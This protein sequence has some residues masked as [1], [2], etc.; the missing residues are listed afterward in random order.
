MQPSVER[1]LRT[2][3]EEIADRDL[4]DGYN[5]MD[6]SGAQYETPV[7]KV[8]AYCWCDG[9]LHKDGCPPNFEWRDFRACWYKHAGRGN[10]QNRKMKPREA[11]EMLREC[12]DSL[13]VGNPGGEERRCIALEDGQ[14]PCACGH[15]KWMH[16]EKEG[17]TGAMW[18]P[19]WE[20][21]GNLSVAVLPVA[22]PAKVCR[23]VEFQEPAK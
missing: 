14:R 9:E 3:G 18:E 20:E 21:E 1:A 5:P 12:L 22:S 4:V 8:R 19:E 7:F 17:C 10:S 16:T 6:N 13:P 15:D 11:A 2:L 23:C